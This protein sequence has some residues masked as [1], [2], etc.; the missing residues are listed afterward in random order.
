MAILALMLFADALAA[1]VRQMAPAF[2]DSAL[3]T[4]SR[5]FQLCWRAE[6]L[7]R[8]FRRF[9]SRT[10]GARR[11]TPPII[12]SGFLGFL[13]ALVTL[14]LAKASLRPRSR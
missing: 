2:A 12:L 7:A 11:T 9:G 3:G 13:V 10:V 14:M 8:P 6:A 1:A 4:V 5:A